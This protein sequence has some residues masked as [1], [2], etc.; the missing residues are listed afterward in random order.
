MT[1]A[2]DMPIKNDAKNQVTRF[3]SMS[4]SP[5]P[6]TVA[7]ITINNAPATFTSGAWNKPK[8]TTP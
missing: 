5:N 2:I 8:T 1:N 3:V 4:T 7:A 6:P